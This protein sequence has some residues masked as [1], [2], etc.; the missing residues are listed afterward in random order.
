MA[1]WPYAAAK[2]RLFAMQAPGRAAIVG[3]LAEAGF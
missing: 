2:A 1:A 3:A